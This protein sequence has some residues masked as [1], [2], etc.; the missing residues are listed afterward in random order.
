MRL[1]RGIRHIDLPPGGCVATIG[2]FDG[3]HI[4]HRAVIENLAAEGRRLGLPVVVVLFEPQPREFFEPATAPARLMNL[5]EKL[6]ALA[7]LPLDWVLLLRF[8]HAL[9]NMSAEGFI[10]RILIDTLRVKRLVIG[11]DF[12]FGR[13]RTGD[14]SALVRAGVEAGFAVEDT[15][16]VLL[17]G[18]RVSSTWIRE[19]L[20]AGDMARA[21]RLLGRPYALCGRVGPG[22]MLGRQLG[23]PTA[24]I[25]L[26][27]K[28][29]P[30]RGV[31]AVTMT[32]AADRTL[33]GV[34]NV[35]VRPTV[36]RGPTLLLETHLFDFAGDLYGRRVY[37]RFHHKLRDERRFADVRALAEQIARDAE[38]A[39]AYFATH[40]IR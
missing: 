21:E 39:R 5:R 7:Q 28:N 27:R 24:N 34:A 10:Q 12:R 17:D 2:N 31:F 26:D 8:D 29:S 30:V 35:G 38:G 9:A 3:V 40:T 25:R 23:F 15:E 4:G 19:A 32:G 18:V 37:V 36:D 22:A 14:F 20:A 13:G 1:A 16:S 6:I 11:D 33:T